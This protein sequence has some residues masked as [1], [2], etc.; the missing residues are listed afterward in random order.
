M[1]TN[2]RIIDVMLHIPALRPGDPDSGLVYVTEDGHL[3]EVTVAVESGQATVELQ[4]FYPNPKSQLD[5][6]TR[7]GIV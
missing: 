6:W 5:I 7:L 1:K 3:W 4:P 2:K